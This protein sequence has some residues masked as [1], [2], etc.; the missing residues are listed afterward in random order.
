MSEELIY[1]YCVTGQLPER[2]P[3]EVFLTQSNGIFAVACKVSEDAFTGETFK[4][5]LSDIAWIEPKVRMHECMI[6]KVMAHSTVVPFRFGTLFKTSESLNAMLDDY[7][8]ELKGLL[9]RLKDKE[10]W[11]LKIYCDLQTVKSSVNGDERLLKLD[12]ELASASGGKR[13]I[14]MK[15]KEGLIED[16]LDEKVSECRQ[17]SFE[18]LNRHSVQAR[19]NSPLPKDATG[20]KTEMLFNAAFLVD[21]CSLR[22]FLDCANYLKGKYRGMGLLFECSGPW[23]P[24]NFCE[25][26]TG[27]T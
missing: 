16:L 26:M 5:N 13:Y 11:G 1:L 2:V 24:Y 12:E 19:I 17:E 6:E 10:E 21:R 27:T 7:H 20:Q 8:N 23:P 25:A 4:K 14:L 3:D 22:G 18:T 15:R 9:T